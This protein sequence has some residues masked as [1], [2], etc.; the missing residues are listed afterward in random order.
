[1]NKKLV[2]LNKTLVISLSIIF[3]GTSLVSAIEIN[4]ENRTVTKEIS[5]L[6]LNEGLVGY[7]S[8]D[9]G[10]GDIAF[11]YSRNNNGIIHGA[12]WATGI[13][14]KALGFDSEM[15]NHVN[16]GDST[17]LEMTDAL[18]VSAWIFPTGP[19]SC[20]VTGGAIVMKEGEYLLARDRDGTITFAL[21]NDDPGWVLV[22]TEYKA[23]LYTW[24]HV[25]WTYS[26]QE[27]ML[28]VV[29]NGGEYVFTHSGN[30]LI[31]DY[32]PDMDDFMIAGRQAE[33]S[34]NQ[35]FD[36]LIDEVRVYNRALSEAEI[37]KLYNNPSGL[38]NTIIFGKL[39]NVDTTGVLIT[40]KAE[41]IRCIRFSPFESYKFSSGE[42]IMV[43]G[44]YS[45]IFTLNFALG[46]F[47]AGI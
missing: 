5:T 9:E 41:K 46:I 19:G 38:K 3:I 40:F 8:F 16:I 33:A 18:S 17:I 13:S 24:T 12:T 20:P 47:K 36:G 10:S 29:I 21:E 1:M 23:P 14:G 28:K 42:L 2:L 43:T 7:W 34:G 35:Y 27:S 31:G 6:G 4:S 44:E 32:H 26:A 22:E 37:Q 15:E 11:D 25:G 30:G 45:G 39:N